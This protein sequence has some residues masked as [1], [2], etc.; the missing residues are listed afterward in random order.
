MTSYEKI[1]EASVS[2]NEFWKNKV[3]D[4]FSG[5]IIN[6]G[7][8]IMRVEGNFAEQNFPPNS[9]FIVDK[10]LPI[11]FD[12]SSHIFIPASERETKNVD[13][14]QKFIHET[15]LMGKVLV[16]VGGGVALDTVLCVAQKLNLKIILVPT[17]VISMSDS[18]IGGK[19]RANK[20]E[21]GVFLKHFYK[22]QYDPSEIFIF[23]NFLQT[24]PDRTVSYGLAEVIKHAFMQSNDLLE[25]LLN[26]LFDP[27][28]NKKSL[29]KAILWSAD[30][31]RICMEVDPE[32]SADGSRLII[33][34]GHAEADRLEKESG[35]TV[36]HGEAVL[37]GMKKDFKDS[38]SDK[39]NK[40]CAKLNIEI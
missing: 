35:F 24:L 25:F 1:L 34:E 9:F 39:F 21:D 10:N 28:K 33:R 4:D 37:R 38:R 32:E 16:A 3:D 26:D 17:S 5:T 20:V 30:L 15:D 11:N 18:S 2:V 6:F 7:K 23:E 40:I 13:F 36:S 8:Y 29:L 14:I 27:F 19:A 31:K 22:S 12:S